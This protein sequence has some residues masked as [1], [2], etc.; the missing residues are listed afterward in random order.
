MTGS[1]KD[2]NPPPINRE[3]FGKARIALHVALWGFYH[4]DSFAE[5][6]LSVVNLGWDA[7]TQGAIYGQLAGAYYGESG[8]PHEWRECVAHSEMIR[9]YGLKLFQMAK[10]MA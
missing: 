10:E 7:D 2:G 6:L 5:G 8:I 3:S 9:S 4:S 1:F